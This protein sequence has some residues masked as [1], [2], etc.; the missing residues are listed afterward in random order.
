MHAENELQLADSVDMNTSAPDDGLILIDEIKVA[1]FS[2][3]GNEIVTKS[4]LDRPNLAGAIRG[5]EDIVFEWL[6]YLDA[7]RWKM[8]PDEAMVDKYLTM[9]Q[10]DN[11][12]SSDDLKRMFA[13]AGYTYEEGREQLKKMQAVNL[14]LGNKVRSS[15]VVPRKE[16]IAYYEDNP[17]YEDMEL[18]IARIVIPFDENKT[19]DQQKRDIKRAVAAKNSPIDWGTAFWVKEED[20]APE[21]RFIFK[22]KQGQ[23]SLP[24]ATAEGFEMYRVIE[25]KE[26]RLKTLDERYQEIVEALTQPKYH[27]LLN[28]YKKEL[29]DSASI[30]YF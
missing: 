30:V 9:I 26:K 25:R 14:M 24:K 23:V 27:E 15:L 2:P 6:A 1:I 20:V 28:K 18:K 10:R 17:E 29:L 7:K 19:R 8:L 13:N 4:D 3:E 5:M 12:L 11:N 21:K 16:V 22:M